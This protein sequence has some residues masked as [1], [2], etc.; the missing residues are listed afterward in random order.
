MDEMV[1]AHSVHLFHD[2]VSRLRCE[3]HSV[4]RRSA[5]ERGGGVIEGAGLLKAVPGTP[6]Q[7]C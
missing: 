4:T 3:G 1:D 5:E 6:H 7:R 2:I